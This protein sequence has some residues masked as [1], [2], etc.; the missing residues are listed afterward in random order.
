MTPFSL[1]NKNVHRNLL[2]FDSNVS[3]S[4][5]PNLSI[6]EK[7]FLSE[8]NLIRKKLKFSDRGQDHF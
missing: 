4:F 5:L 3:I 2:T 7:L 8:K 6:Q 1:N